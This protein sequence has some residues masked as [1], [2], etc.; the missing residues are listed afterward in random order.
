LYGKI[1]TKIIHKPIY[2][3]MDICNAHHVVLLKKTPFEDHQ[4]EYNDLYAV[5][6]SPNNDITKWNVALHILLGKKVKGK[7]QVFYVDKCDSSTFIQTILDD[8]EKLTSVDSIKDFDL[9]IY[10][11]IQDWDPSFQLYQHNCQHFSRYIV[12][13]ALHYP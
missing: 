12:Y 10:R 7:I 8:P 2:E 11:K 1:F 9:D 3:S 4:T 5:D 6:F 13:N